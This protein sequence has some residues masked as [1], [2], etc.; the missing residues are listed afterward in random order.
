MNFVLLCAFGLFAIVHSQEPS[1]DDLKKYAPCFKYGLCEDP[2]TKKQLI[3]CLSPL[4]PKEFQSLFQ[5]FKN[6]FYPI[7]S[8]G[9]T[10]AISEY[11]GFKDATKK[12]EA[13]K[14]IDADF[15]YQKVSNALQILCFHLN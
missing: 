14:V 1:A 2:S 15:F 9:L 12:D 13:D 5:N 10:G 6:N 3:N 4:A 7:V 8:D 11:C